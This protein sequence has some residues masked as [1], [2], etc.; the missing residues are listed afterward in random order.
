LCARALERLMTVLRV[1]TDA[2]MPDLVSKRR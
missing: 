2:N 1:K